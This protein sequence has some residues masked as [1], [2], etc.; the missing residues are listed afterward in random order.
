MSVTAKAYSAADDA[1]SD[2]VPDNH[3]D[4]NAA[5]NAN[6][7]DNTTLAKFGAESPAETITLSSALR[8][9]SGGVDPGLSDGDATA[10]DGRIISSFTSGVGS[11]T[12]V[13]FAEVGII[14]IAA[15]ITDSD[16]LGQAPLP[17]QAW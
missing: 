15:T 12:Q 14:E 10:S 5:N 9:P 6:L 7:A 8:L 16:Y 3:A 1:N 11:T 4:T 13:Y 17:R 2:G